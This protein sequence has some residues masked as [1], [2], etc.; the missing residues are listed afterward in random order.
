VVVLLGAPY[1]V[2]VCVGAARRGAAAVILGVLHVAMGS[3]GRGLTPPDAGR[4]CDVGIVGG[5]LG[6]LALA[7]ALQ[8]SSGFRVTVFERDT[9]FEFRNQGYAITIQ[10]GGRALAKMGLLDKVVRAFALVCL[11]SS[12]GPSLIALSQCRCVPRMWNAPPTTL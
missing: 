4:P 9:S 10:Q 11:F 5:G 1:C 12:V 6:G 3:M 7:R 2:C 8:L